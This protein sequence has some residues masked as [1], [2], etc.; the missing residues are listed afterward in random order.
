[1]LLACFL[2][3]SRKVFIKNLKNFRKKKKISQMR[4]AEKCK[5]STSYIGE[6]E[7]GKKFPSIE[8]IDKIA[9]ALNIKPYF[10]FIEESDLLNK[11][12][13]GVLLPKKTKSNIAEEINRE[14]KIILEKY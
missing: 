9:E 2:M 11:E 1:M 3:D 7:I 14:V 8:M 6:I 13:A 4:L 12:Y 5:T 10:L